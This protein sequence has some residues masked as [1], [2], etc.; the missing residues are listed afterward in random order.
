M[1]KLQ[2]LAENLP[3]CSKSRGRSNYDKA[4]QLIDKL[5]ARGFDI[6]TLLVDP[7]K[8]A[9][10]YRRYMELVNGR[11]LSIPSFNTNEF[12]WLTPN[13]INSPYYFSR[14]KFVLNSMKVIGGGA[15]NHIKRSILKR[16]IGC[17]TQDKINY[18]SAYCDNS[19]RAYVYK[20]SFNDISKAMGLDID[21]KLTICPLK[22]VNN[23][24]HINFN[25]SPGIVE[26]NI[27]FS[28][29]AETALSASAAFTP[30]YYSWIVNPFSPIR[31][32]EVWNAAARPKLK[33]LR[34]EVSKIE[35]SKP[36]CRVISAGS[37]LEQFIGFSVWF[38]VSE[39]IKKA[40]LDNYYGVAIGINRLSD[41]W[42]KLAESFRGAKAVYVGDYSKYDQTI[43]ASLMERAIDYICSLFDTS[44]EPSINYVFNFKQ[45]FR[46]NI[47][48]KVYIIENKIMFKV[49]NGVPSGSLW[50]SLINSICNIIMI[51]EACESMGI[52]HFRP[53]VYG[54]D[55]LI[56]FDEEPPLGFRHAFLKYTE[57]N[58]GVKGNPDDALMCDPDHFFVGYERPVFRPGQYLSGGTSKLKP[59]RIEYSKT[60]FEGYDYAKGTTHR[61]NYTFAGRVKFLQYYFM[62]SGVSIRPWGEVLDRLVNPEESIS[63]PAENRALLISHL[64]DNYHNAHV[65]NWIYQLLYDN[66]FQHNSFNYSTRSWSVD[67]ELYYSERAFRLFKSQPGVEGTRGW[68]RKIDHY[69]NLFEEKCM[70]RFNEKWFKITQIAE[71][72]LSKDIPIPF[73]AVK[74]YM[75]NIIKKGLSSKEAFRD[76]LGRYGTGF[77]V[78]Y[79]MAYNDIC[80]DKSSSGAVNAARAAK[81]AGGFD[82]GSSV[83]LLKGVSPIVQYRIS[84]MILDGSLVA[85]RS[86]YQGSLLAHQTIF[87]LK[88]T[89]RHCSMSDTFVLNSINIGQLFFETVKSW[90]AHLFGARQRPS[91]CW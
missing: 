78:L 8:E 23:Y 74:N 73:Y 19:N 3:T 91:R 79:H 36:C 82:F 59:I 27:G 55:H 16:R 58:F 89:N 29:K 38:P 25:S 53:V 44:V 17:S 32:S 62:Q 1:R 10:S 49:K 5:S 81:Q 46:A 57:D 2:R 64:I 15:E 63:T 22:E 6:K 18:V 90:R 43:P 41:D 7:Q 61:W 13:R 30:L 11:G 56:I 51:A 39:L 48:N 47:I 21:L 54:D 26:R 20:V 14:N 72:I 69:V 70:F 60:P 24:I 87:A 50:T 9:N 77:G 84:L 28:N 68:Y 35:Q 80:F 76:F 34:E 40:F 83:L 86:P 66:E 65:R 67:N 31:P 88:A 85:E 42:A 71:E 12:E 75:F 4:R 45:Y 33:N 52:V 37:L